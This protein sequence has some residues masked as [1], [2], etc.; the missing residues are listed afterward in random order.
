MKELFL[1]GKGRFRAPPPILGSYTVCASDRSVLAKWSRKWDN[2]WDTNRPSPEYRET[3]E[4]TRRGVIFWCVSTPEDEG[5]QES[6]DWCRSHQPLTAQEGDCWQPPRHFQ[7][8]GTCILLEQVAG[9]CIIFFLF[10]HRQRNRGNKLEFSPELCRKNHWKGCCCGCFSL[11]KEQ[12]HRFYKHY[13]HH[14]KK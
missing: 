8:M 4:G 1:W 7:A 9:I 11:S 13:I 3:G 6:K 10:L 12:I 2:S 14:Y 5:K